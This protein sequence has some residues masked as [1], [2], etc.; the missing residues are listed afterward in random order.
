[1]NNIKTKGP[2]EGILVLDLTNYL[3]GPFCTM[4]LADLGA[5]V[6][7]IERFDKPKAS[8]PFLNGERVYDLSVNRSKKSMNLNLKTEVGKEIF[9]EL[10]SKADILVENFKPG[11]MNKL[12]LGYESL[13]EINSN[14]IYCAISGFGYTGPYKKRGALDMVIQGM[15]GLMSLTGEPEGRPVKAGT[16]VSDIFSGLF[17]F[18]AITSSLYNRELSGEG[19]FIDIAMLDC[20]FACLENAVINTCVF[21]KNPKRVGNMHSTSVPFQSFKTKDGEI[22]ITCSRDPAFYRLCDAMNK[23]ELKK[24]EKFSKAESRRENRY[25]LEKVITE[26]TEKLTTKECEKILNDFEVPNGVINTMMDICED[27]QIE[28]RNMIVEVDHK[29]AGK[30]KMAANPIKFLRKKSDLYYPAPVLG[31]DTFY[32]MKEKL[33][34]SEDKI[35]NLINEQLGGIK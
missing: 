16:S 24:D 26:F 6:I 5:E 31:E 29:V 21:N 15:S 2:L 7:K 14:L 30:Y 12:G 9:K 25:Q 19:D 22:I 4:M 8:G 28:A 10:V 13:K 3:S 27:P 34:L 1:M 32:V 35:Q 18:G 11:T 17:A 23:P 33:G 20:T